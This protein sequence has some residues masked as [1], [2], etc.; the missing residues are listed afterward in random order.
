VLFL[1]LAPSTHLPPP[2]PLCL[3]STV[4]VQPFLITSQSLLQDLCVTPLAHPSILNP[5]AQGFTS[6]WGV[7]V[8]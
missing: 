4:Q 1:H 2:P 5:A 7:G 8:L 6:T 3:S